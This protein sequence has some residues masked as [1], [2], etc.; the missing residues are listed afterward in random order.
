MSSLEGDVGC[1]SGLETTG[2]RRE[3]KIRVVGDLKFKK[4]NVA[5]RG[6]QA[7]G[8]AAGFL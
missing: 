8:E 6:V 5:T 2:Y 1:E 4:E 7:T 3:K